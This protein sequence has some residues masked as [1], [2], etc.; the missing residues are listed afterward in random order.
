MIGKTRSSQKIEKC[1]ELRLLNDFRGGIL[2]AAHSE[3]SKICGE[4]VG[5]EDSLDS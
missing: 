4:G 1:T 3:G 5:E 2:D